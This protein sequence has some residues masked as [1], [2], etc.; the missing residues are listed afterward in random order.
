MHRRLLKLHGC[1]VHIMQTR[2]AHPAVDR[3]ADTKDPSHFM[4]SQSVYKVYLKP[5][6]SSIR[7][8]TSAISFLASRRF[9]NRYWICWPIATARAKE[10]RQTQILNPRRY[11]GASSP[12]KSCDPTKP[13]ELAAMM[14]GRQYRLGNVELLLT[15]CHRNRSLLGRAT[16]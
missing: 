8:S 6:T 7:P 15:H 3:Y 13:P 10:M 1:T 9:D 4:Y 2:H 11:K 12:R 16:V 14:T 5:S